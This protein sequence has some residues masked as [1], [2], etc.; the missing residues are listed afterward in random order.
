M[1]KVKRYYV[2]CLEVDE[3][4]EGVPE[5]EEVINHLQTELTMNQEEFGI[6]DAKAVTVAYMDIH[7]A[8]R[9]RLQKA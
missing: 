7:P 4:H 6:V 5:D 9:R 8:T 2:L 3:D 1:N